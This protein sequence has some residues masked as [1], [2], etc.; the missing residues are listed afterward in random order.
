MRL[1]DLW[2]ITPPTAPLDSAQQTLRDDVVADLARGPIAGDDDLDTAI[3][4]T[5]LIRAE[6]LV[7]GTGG[8]PDLTDTQTRAAQQALKL[9]LGR[10]GITLELPWR[11]MTGFRE[12]WIREGCAN[13]YQARRDLVAKYFEPVRAQLEEL[14]EKR[15]LAVLADPVSPHAATG[16]PAVDEELTEMKRLF[17]SA[18]TAQ[19][20][21]DVGNR[22]TAVLEAL[23]R[24]VYRAADHL[25]PGETEPAAANTK[26]R[27]GRYVEVELAGRD[28]VEVRAVATKVIE[29]AQAVKHSMTPS[30]RD[31]G[32]CADSVIL[33][34]NILR[35][36][37][38]AP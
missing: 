3:A 26:Q 30:R 12:Y 17:R 36:I 25:R 23:S 22:A 11:D 1:D 21:R 33:L 38:E 35:R 2:G 5:E 8:T 9:T 14:E 10:H 24:T 7:K 32:I 6:L 28:N 15:F 31:A 19:D 16:W 27:I 29:L 34:A 20:Y 4:L 18:T 37:D 13:S